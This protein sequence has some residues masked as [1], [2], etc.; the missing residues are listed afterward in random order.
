MLEMERKTGVSVWNGTDLGGQ[1][2]CRE[3]WLATSPQAVHTV[4]KTYFQAVGLK[5]MAAAE[6]VAARLVH[7][8]FG[9]EAHF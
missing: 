9:N 1:Q 5:A 3:G 7:P 2:C 6:T 8:R 4:P